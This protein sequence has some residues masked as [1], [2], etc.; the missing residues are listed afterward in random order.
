MDH[1]YVGEPWPSLE[2]YARPLLSYMHVARHM[3]GPETPIARTLRLTR[4]G[5]IIGDL[6]LWLLLFESAGHKFHLCLGSPPVSA[7]SHHLTVRLPGCLA[8]IKLY[9]IAIANASRAPW[10]L[11]QDASGL[12][13]ETGRMWHNDGPL[14]PA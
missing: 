1:R 3:T 2:L 12:L 10:T 5:I 6:G 14:P 11:A 8:A 9:S 4:I 7:P 13:T